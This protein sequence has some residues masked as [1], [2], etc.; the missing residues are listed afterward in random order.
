MW[1]TI[2]F[3]N[4]DAP[5]GDAAPAADAAPSVESSAPAEAAPAEVSPEPA[6][7][8][9]AESPA[10]EPGWNGEMD[11]LGKQAWFSALPDDV[12]KQVEDGLKAKWSNLEGGYTKKFQELA[13][14]K[15]APAEW[16]TERTSLTE[17]REKAERDLQLF[18]DIFGDEGKDASQ[19]I[20]AERKRLF[21]EYEAKMAKAAEEHASKLTPM[22][23]ELVELR[24]LRAEVEAERQAAYTKQV[25]ELAT[26]M[27][28]K[29]ADVFAN[30]DA[31]DKFE[32]MLMALD[33]DDEM[34]DAADFIRKKYGI[35]AAKIPAAAEH[36]SRG[37]GPRADAR[38][39]PDGLPPDEMI[40]LAVERAAS[41]AR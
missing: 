6:P 34:D 3:L 2:R 18:Q 4:A 17:A 9:A 35:K 14:S 13:E 5:G 27:A 24:A 29:Y 30:K 1:R 39:I 22:E 40:R 10:A 32:K 20:E 15:K 8:P 12:R 28:S 26:K 7:E 21:D 31:S 11:H 16:E 38:S 33:S 19:K 37:D 36:A 41:R 23:K 25:E